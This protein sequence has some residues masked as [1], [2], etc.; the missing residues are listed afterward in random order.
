MGAISPT[1]GACFPEFMGQW[2]AM[3]LP[4]SE[5]EPCGRQHI[6]GAEDAS[7]AMP[8]AMGARGIANTAMMTR[9]ACARRITQRLS[10]LGN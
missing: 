6:I 10:Q 4:C 7:Q 3:G 5:W 9:I 2:Q 8:Q 1:S